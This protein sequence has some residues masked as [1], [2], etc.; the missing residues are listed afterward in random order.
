MKEPIV[1]PQNVASR[2]V[3]K[4]DIGLMNRNGILTVVSSTGV[5]KVAG[6]DAVTEANIVAALGFSPVDPSSLPLNKFDAIV[7]PAVT[8]DAGD[9]YSVGS[10]WI[11]VAGNESYRCVDSTVGAAIW[12]ETTF[13]AVEVAA[14][15]QGQNT[16][17]VVNPSADYEVPLPGANGTYNGQRLIY[18][19]KPTV[20]INLTINAGILIPSDSAAV[21][22]KALTQDKLS[23]VQIVWG[24][25][26]WMFVTSL[27]EY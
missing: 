4:S 7:A 10:L 8:D 18:H 17:T 23:I 6:I 22:P 26:G 5:E 24:V 20:G 15:I 21:F 13:D 27:G 1:L 3:A 16:A 14:M 9:G 19:I 2:G 11:D 12:I 25:N